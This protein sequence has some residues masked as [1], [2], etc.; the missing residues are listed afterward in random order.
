MFEI[1]IIYTKGAVQS[2]VT[3]DLYMF[4][5]YFTLLF[6]LS[7]KGMDYLGLPHKITGNRHQQS[8]DLL[9]IGIQPFKSQSTH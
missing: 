1:R 5:I 7:L 3:V 4:I 8:T 6:Y 9:A 2:Y